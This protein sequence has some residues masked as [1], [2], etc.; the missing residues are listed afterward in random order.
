MTAVFFLGG[1]G[2]GGGSIYWQPRTQGYKDE[3]YMC[4]ACVCE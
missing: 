4:Y 3:V 2:G 1:G